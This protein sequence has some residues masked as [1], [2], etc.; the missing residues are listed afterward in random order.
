MS[1]FFEIDPISGIRTDFTWCERT[2]EYTLHRTCDV[3]P[4]LNR[5]RG[6][7]AAVGLN[8]GG[9]KAGWWHYACLPPIVIVQMRAKGINVFDQND[10]AR[11]FE[12]INTHYPHL[13]TTTGNEGGREKILFT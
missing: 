4:Y 11:V 8:R 12:E 9:I 3:E 2:Q 10:S 1:D 5:A 13:R 6:K 7:A